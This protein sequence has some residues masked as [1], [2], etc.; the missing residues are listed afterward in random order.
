M[1]K[2]TKQTQAI[3]ASSSQDIIQRLQALNESCATIC[4]AT[5]MSKSQVSLVSSGKRQLG[6]KYFRE[7]VKLAIER[8]I[9]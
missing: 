1:A 4:E 3:I 9:F 5:G 6:E 7:L 8:G 2:A